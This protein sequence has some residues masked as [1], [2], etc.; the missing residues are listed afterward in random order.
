MTGDMTAWTRLML[1]FLRRTA[2]ANLWRVERLAELHAE[3]A[4]AIRE[5]RSD[6]I[7]P[8]LAPCALTQP[9]FTIVDALHAIGGT[10]ASVNMAAARLVDIGILQVARGTRRDRLFRA[11]G[12]VDFLGG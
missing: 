8:M 9:A 12:G 3:W 6:S 7:I 11:P 2:E 5:Y 4:L 10:F 1:G